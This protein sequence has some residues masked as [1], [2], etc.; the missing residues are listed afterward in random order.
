M[1]SISL[2]K[3]KEIIDNI[4]EE[5]TIKKHF[6]RVLF[7]TR[8]VCCMKNIWIIVVLELITHEVCDAIRCRPNRLYMIHS[9]ESSVVCIK[10]VGRKN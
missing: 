10:I 3:A 2:V 5:G 4:L 7:S 1:T 9:S 8:I 6:S